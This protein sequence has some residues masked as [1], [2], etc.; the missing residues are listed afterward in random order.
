MNMIGRILF[1]PFLPGI[2]VQRP[3]LYRIAYAWCNDPALADDVVQETLSK[4]WTRRAQLR[5]AAALKGWMCR[6]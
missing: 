1:G 4:A 5:D 3:V 2:E 6:S